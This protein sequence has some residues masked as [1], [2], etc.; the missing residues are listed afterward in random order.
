VAIGALSSSV[1]PRSIL[2]HRSGPAHLVYIGR[3]SL[4]PHT[5]ACAVNGVPILLELEPPHHHTLLRGN[6]C[7]P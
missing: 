4:P 6:H 2:K 1:H 3:D 7:R 5:H